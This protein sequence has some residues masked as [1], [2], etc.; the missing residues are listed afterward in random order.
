MPIGT[1]CERL[2]KPLSD[3]SDFTKILLSVSTKPRFPLMARRVLLGF[4]LR[5]HLH[6][7]VFYSQQ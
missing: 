6:F 3:K 4:S 1:V 2:E 7:E 5:V